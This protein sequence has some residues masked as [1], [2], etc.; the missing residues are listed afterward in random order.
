MIERNIERF[1]VVIVVFDLGTFEH[2]VTEAREDFDH[3][4]ANQAERVAMPEWRDTARQR[5]VECFR[6]ELGLEF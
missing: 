2:L 5:D 4:I 1:E 6:C 3:F